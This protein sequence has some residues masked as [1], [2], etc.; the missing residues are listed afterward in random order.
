MRELTVGQL[1]TIDRRV[2]RITGFDPMG[3]EERQVELEDRKTGERLR[4]PV[5][6]LEP[7]AHDNVAAA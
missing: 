6:R 5:E 1:V 3:M 4:L 2:L 7:V